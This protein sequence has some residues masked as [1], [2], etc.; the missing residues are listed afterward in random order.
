MSTPRRHATPAELG[1]R[2]P[3]EWAPHRGTWLSWPHR[4]SSWPGK[5]GPVPGVFAE[6]VQLLAPHEEVHINVTGPDMADEIAHLLK[7]LELPAGRVILHDNPTNDAWC[8]DHGPCFVQRT[9]NGRREEAIVDWGYN[10]WGGKYP[11]FDLDDVVPTRI[12]KEYGLPVF[13][14]GIV[15]EG[16]SLDVNGVGTLLTTEACLLHPNR[17]P[18]LS[19]ADI[20]RFL[21]DYLGVRHIL[22]LGDGIVG[23]DTDGHVDDMT[24]FTDERTVVTVVEDDPR[25]EN[26]E[27]LQANLE[28]LRT[29][30]DQDGRPLEI[31]TLPMPRPLHQDGQRLPAS[32]ANFY[33]ANGV[34]LL[35]AYDPE[36]DEI[37]RATLQARF[38]T[39]HVAL[40]DA[41]DL[42]WGLG[43]F[44]CV[45]Q[46]WPAL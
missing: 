7:P 3:A 17:N 14:P 16:G 23:D 34:V 11:P 21:K 6:M 10:A 46:Q 22:W 45:S 12:G 19:R 36:R 26:H 35:P 24:R 28:R 37:A 42:V 20:E 44:H 2:M 27:P 9:V 30:T 31:V 4:E 8:R 25:D 5:F 41:V 15:M 13:H 33:I 39:R 40:V 38:P 18:D 32:Y 1:Y 43:A 29:M